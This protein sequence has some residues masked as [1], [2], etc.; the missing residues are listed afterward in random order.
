RF[1]SAERKDMD[2]RETD[3]FTN[4]DRLLEFFVGFPRKTDDHVGRKRRLIEPLF[5]KLATIDKSLTGPAPAH[6]AK[7]RV[8]TALHGNVQVRTDAIP[9]VCHHVD[10]FACNFR[11]LDAA[12]SNSKIARQLA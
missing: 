12:E 2:F 3:L 1:P 8:G 5:S 6:S 7:H 10:Q 4:L 11:G 9:M